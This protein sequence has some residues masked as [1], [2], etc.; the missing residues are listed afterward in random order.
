ML[1]LLCLA[2]PALLGGSMQPFQQFCRTSINCDVGETVGGNITQSDVD[3]C[4]GSCSCDINCGQTMSCCFEE[5]NIKYTRQHRKECVEPY[6][7]DRK[8]VSDVEI[9]GVMMVT[10]C[11][12]QTVQC[13]SINGQTNIGP[14]VGQNS[15]IFLNEECATCNNVSK[16]ARWDVKLLLTSNTFGFDSLRYLGARNSKDDQSRG[17]TVFL[18]IS[19]SKPITCDK[20]SFR[21]V[22]YSSCP[23]EVYIDLCKSVILPYSTMSGLSRIDYKNV[24][25]YL[26]EKKDI[27]QCYPGNEKS[28]T[29]SYSLILDQRISTDAV[30]AYFSRNQV[31]T[32]S[33]DHNYLPHPYEV[34]LFLSILVNIC[35]ALCYAYHIAINWI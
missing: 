3:R 2:K 20:Y 19:T 4:C 10:Q 30:G 7:G 23:N 8:M 34:F 35:I 27:L 11:L 28:V 31:D 33:C 18:P 5:D 17:T 14:V 25:C 21:S 15:E 9:R 26:C 12:D 29:G 16:F 22:S 1:M 6:I 13:K 32:E 24:F